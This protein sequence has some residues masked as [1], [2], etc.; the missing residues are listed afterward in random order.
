LKQLIAIP[1]KCTGCGRCELACSFEHFKV[2]D[3]ELSAIH[4]LRLEREPLDA[5]LFCIQCGLCAMEGVC[6]HDAIYRDPNTFS[7]VIDRARC[8]GCERCVEVC[9]YGVITIDHVE[10]KAIKCDLCGGDPAC[11]KACPEGALAYV[12][13]NEAAYYKRYFFA[14]LQEKAMVPI[15]PYPAEGSSQL[16]NRT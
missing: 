11:V 14:K 10:K 13:V 3:P 8:D 6:P 1:E 9:P 2:F 15:V 12:D 16:N 4:V 5:P 7:V